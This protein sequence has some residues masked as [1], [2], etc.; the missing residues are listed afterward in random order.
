MGDVVNLRRAR[1]Q[2]ARTAAEKESAE[3]RAR[4]GRTK[5]EKKR[6]AKATDLLA[7]QLNN[8]KLDRRDDE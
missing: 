4:F 3:A 7:R 5:A 8:V 6:E 1:K 2:K